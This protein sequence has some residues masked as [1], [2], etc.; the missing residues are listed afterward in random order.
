M[1]KINF[2]AIL[3][4]SASSI[5]S[6]Q[7]NDSNAQP[8]V[9]KDFHS[10]KVLHVFDVYLTQ[11]NEE[12]VAVSARD[13]K[14]LSQIKT[15]VKDGQLRV[16]HDG[17]NIHDMNTSKMKLKIY[18]SFVNLDEVDA[19]KGSHVYAVGNWKDNELKKKLLKAN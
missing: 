15:E 12:S 11:G 10:L 8:R 7:F 3:L 17:G 19:S 9:A 6:Q 18:I 16:W 14:Y 1:K 2:L 13:K 4:L 5:F